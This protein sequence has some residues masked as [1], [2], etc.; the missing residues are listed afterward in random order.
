MTAINLDLDKKLHFN[1]KRKVT[2]G[3]QTYNVVF[4]DTVS[5]AIVEAQVEVADFYK[6]IN[7]NDFDDL[8]LQQQKSE[9]SDSFDELVETVQN[10]LDAILGKKSAGK[11]IYDYYDHQLYALLKTFEILRKTSDELS[12]IKEQEERNAREER[13]QAYLPKKRGH[14]RA[15]THSRA[16]N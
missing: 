4:N 12:G 10:A 6:R 8:T 16:K 9:L 15:G 11:K 7:A 14:R 1:F 2:V 13:R 5:K 3:G